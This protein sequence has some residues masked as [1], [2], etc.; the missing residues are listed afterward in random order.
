MPLRACGESGAVTFRIHPPPPLHPSCPVDHVYHPVLS[1][2]GSGVAELV[3]PAEPAPRRPST[4]GP[5][6]CPWEPGAPSKK[7]APTPESAG[8]LPG[9]GPEACKW[10]GGISS[11]VSWFFEGSFGLGGSPERLGS[12]QE[13]ERE[14]PWA[15]LFPGFEIQQCWAGRDG[16]VRKALGSVMAGSEGMWAHLCG[17]IHRHAGDTHVFMWAHAQTCLSTR[18]HVSRHT[19]RNTF[20]H[21]RKYT[22]GQACVHVDTV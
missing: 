5:G 17:Y 2:L 18:L 16:G 21:A 14:S 19:G 4:R 11:T 8:D 1:E 20:T 22:H 9:N 7:T 15:K 10:P 13:G 6:S 12:K 3:Q